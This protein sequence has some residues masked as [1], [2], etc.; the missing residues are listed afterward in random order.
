MAEQ[1]RL[2]PA[3]RQSSPARSPSLGVGSSDREEQKH[4]QHERINSGNLRKPEGS[5]PYKLIGT[6]YLPY[7]VLGDLLVSF[8]RLIP[9]FQRMWR[10]G[11]SLMFGNRQM[12]A[13]KKGRKDDWQQ[14]SQPHLSP[15][16]I[17]ESVLL[18]HRAGHVEKVIKNSQCGF[19]RNNLTACYDEMTGSVDW[20]R[21][22]D[23]INGFMLKGRAVV[24]GESER[25]KERTE[26]TLWNSVGTTAKPCI[27]EWSALNSDTGWGQTDKRAA[28][29]ERPWE[30]WKASR[31][32][33][34]HEPVV[35]SGPGYKDGQQ[36]P[37]LHGQEHSLIKGKVY[38][39]SPSTCYTT[40]KVMWLVWGVLG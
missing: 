35:T 19:T 29:Q 18:E 27:W 25:L 12:L 15:W 34:V 39:P 7:W 2:M 4:Q 21:A 1:V 23:I 24:I 10:W 6:D 8:A 33:T 5:W 31:Q 3:L 20:E 40:F 38:V 14:A 13:F 37:E 26:E 17:M 30:L 32:H 9:H 16:Q 22:G 36:N 11:S 28:L